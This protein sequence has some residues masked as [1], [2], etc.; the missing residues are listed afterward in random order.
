MQMQT[1]RITEK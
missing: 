1:G